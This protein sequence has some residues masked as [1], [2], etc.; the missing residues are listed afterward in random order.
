MKKYNSSNRFIEMKRVSNQSMIGVLPINKVPQVCQHLGYVFHQK[1]NRKG[2]F[3]LLKMQEKGYTFKQKRN[4]KGV[5]LCRECIT[6]RQFLK[7][8]VLRANFQQFC[9]KKGT[10]RQNLQGKQHVFYPKIATERVSF[11]KKLQQK[12]YCFGDRVGIPAYKN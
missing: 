12:G 6:R 9:S 10:F 4:R 1:R 2:V 5:F 11:S 7:F 8:S 3:F